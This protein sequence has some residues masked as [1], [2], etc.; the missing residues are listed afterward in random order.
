[1]SVAGWQGKPGKAGGDEVSLF[2]VF[3]IGG[4]EVQAVALSFFRPRDDTRYCLLR[5]LL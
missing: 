2:T 4:H 1:M 5:A 3:R